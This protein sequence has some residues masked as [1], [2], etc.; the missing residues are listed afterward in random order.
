[1][2]LKTSNRETLKNYF[3][4]NSKPTAGNFA[5]LIDGMLNKQEDGLYKPAGEPLG[6]QAERD[7]AG[8][9]KVLNLY[10]S[11]GDAKAAWAL[12]LTPWI[13]PGNIKT[14][15]PGLSF[16]DA[17]GKSKLFIDEGS[18]NV[19]V[20]TLEPGSFR[21]AVQGAVQILD[22]NKDANALGSLHLGPTD[23]RSNLRLGYHADYSWIQSHGGKPLLVNPAGNDVGIGTAG[24]AP[25]ARLEVQ[26]GAIMPAAGNAAAAGVQFAPEPGAGGADSAWIRYYARK[27]DNRT[28]EIGV[29]G[30]ADDHLAL[31]SSGNVGIGTVEPTHKFHVKSGAAVGLFESTDGQAFLRLS[32]KEGI[33]KRVEITNRA[34]G[35]LSLWVNGADVFNILQNGNVGIG[36]IEPKR[37][38]EV[39]GTAKADALQLGDKWRLSGVGDAHTRDHGWG[40]EW[41]RLFDAADTGYYGGLAAGKFWTNK[42]SYQ[43]SDLRS[44]T[45]VS[46]LRRARESILRLRGVRFR[47]RDAAEDRPYAIGVIAQEV[48]QVFPEAVGIGPD[49]MKGVDYTVLTAALIETVKEQQSQIDELRARLLGRVQGE[50]PTEE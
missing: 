50:P 37:T 33:E 14:A 28:L 9:S 8:Q 42:D 44:K 39:K 17:D 13:D 4:K 25:R 20:G 49:G 11:F 36:T 5:E 26:G 35:R 2:E 29:G 47:W 21:L 3:L 34:G 38:L 23:T 10:R 27:G 6:V 31:M 40:P 45:D 1:M 19:G 7:G 15:R 46:L 32:T 41:L 43:Q 24:A 48:E 30:N 12:C 16:G 18:G 22:Q